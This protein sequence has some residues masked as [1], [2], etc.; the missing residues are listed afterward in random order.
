MRSMLS[1]VMR[2]MATNFTRLAVRDEVG[3]ALL[4]QF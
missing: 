3:T 2:S 1:R 4:L